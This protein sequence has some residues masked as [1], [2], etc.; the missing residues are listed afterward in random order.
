MSFVRTTPRVRAFL[1]AM[2]ISVLA[3]IVASSVATGGLRIGASVIAAA[4]VMHFSKSAFS[5]VVAGA[6]TAALWSA[7]A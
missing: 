7:L 2:S 3:A 5:A 1:E 6:A 4:V